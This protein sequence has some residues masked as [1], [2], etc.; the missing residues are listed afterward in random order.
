MK[1]HA[2]FIKKCGCIIISDKTDVFINLAQSA[3]TVF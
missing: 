1:D 2:K 3:H